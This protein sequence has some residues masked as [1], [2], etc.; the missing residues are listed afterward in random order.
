MV[1]ETPTA[2]KLAGP[3][4]LVPDTELLPSRP[5]PPPLVRDDG[6]PTPAPPVPVFLS[7]TPEKESSYKVQP[8]SIPV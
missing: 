4:M 5:G 6:A 1:L 3:P 2:K 7:A 8:I